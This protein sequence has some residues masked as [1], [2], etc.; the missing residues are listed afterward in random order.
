MNQYFS[1]P[2]FRQ[3]PLVGI[4]RGYSK[5]H[6]QQI[7][8]AG[9]KAG[10]TTFEITR[11]TKGAMTM[12]AEAADRYRGKM[13]IGVG[14]VCNLDQLE[15]S[16]AAGAQ[17]V[18]TPIIDSAVIR[19][20]NEKNIPI[21]CGALTPTE[22]YRAWSLGADMVKLFPAELH[23][24]AYLKSVLAPLDE[25]EIMPTGGVGPDNMK[26]YWE[27]GAKG[28]GM[29]SQLFNKALI[30]REDWL[31]LE[32]HFSSLCHHFNSFKEN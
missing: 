11:N 27:Y 10:L 31:A 15:E 24:P 9:Y 28:F 21:F 30:N 2:L 7:L 18:V 32:Q 20:C 23:G 25:I 16:L 22:I 6:T 13:N 4:L 14:T 29:G 17:F 19:A 3:M 8:E 12:I 1:F 26:V 5:H